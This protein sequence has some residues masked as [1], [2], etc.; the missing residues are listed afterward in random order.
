VRD[1]FVQ[2]SEVLR[3]ELFRIGDTP[4]SVST[5][6]TLVLILIA[7]FWLSKSLRRLT[8]RV[9]SSKN[10]SAGNTLGA[11]IH[12]V[13]LVIG[14]SIA[15]STAGINLTAL[16]AAGAV[17]AVGL[18]FAMQSIVQN[19]VSGIILLTERTITPGHV[20]EVEG[21]VV[22]VAEMGIRASI[23][24]SRD[25]EDIIIP[26]SVLSQ[27]SVK[28]YTLRDSLFRIRVPVGVTY[29]SDMKLVKTT[30]E[31]V[32]AEVNSRWG[33]GAK[34]SLVLMTGFGDNSV[35]WQV[36]V[37]MSD[38]WEFQAA[39]SD[40]HE[41]VWWAFQDRG[42]VIAFPQ[43]DVHLDPPLTDSILRIAGKVE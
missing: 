34:H 7:S 38:P 42:I 41:S 23:V 36:S 14:L 32:A 15:L 22:K 26:N 27:N 25:G 5:L 8:H 3:Q 6:V 4:I 43:L 24:Q 13:V 31:T 17:F 33:V 19:F 40:L 28:N 16:F 20:L 21:V 35:N 12:Y 39:A 9:F 11:L 29:N 30:L 2:A 1:F 10:P 18:G 37:W